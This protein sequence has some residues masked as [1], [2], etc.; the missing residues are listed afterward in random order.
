MSGDHCVRAVLG[1]CVVGLALAEETLYSPRL[2]LEPLL[3]SHADEL[4]EPLQDD[5]LYTFIPQDPPRSREHLEVRYRKLALRRSPDGTEVWL[6]W[7]ARLRSAAQAVGTFEATICP[8]R[9]ALLAYMIFRPFQRQGY[10]E[11]ECRR[12]IER[13]S[14]AYGVGVFAAEIDTR[15][16]ASIALVE[17][18]GFS[19]VAERRNADFFKGARSD[20]YRYELAPP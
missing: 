18:L 14:Q 15:N 4:F 16:R 3:P 7:V 8:E 13:L 5:R 12:V 2:A 17:R 6:N 10:A 11:E 20:E 1:G 19:R 9:Q